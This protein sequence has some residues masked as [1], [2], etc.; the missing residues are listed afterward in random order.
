MKIRIDSV[1][2]RSLP[3]VSDICDFLIN[4]PEKCHF[5]FFMVLTTI[6]INT[7]PPNPYTPLLKK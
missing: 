2:F 1:I 4:F 6:K 7:I 5:Q 3:D